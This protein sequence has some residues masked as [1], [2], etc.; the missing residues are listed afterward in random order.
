[1]WQAHRGNLYGNCLP[2]L[3]QESSP[4]ENK[5]EEC[6]CRCIFLGVWPENRQLRRCKEVYLHPTFQTSLSTQIHL[7]SPLSPPA[8]SSIQ[9]FWTQILSPLKSSTLFFSLP[10]LRTPWELLLPG[11]SAFCALFPVLYIIWERL[12]FVSFLPLAPVSPHFSLNT[13]VTRCLLQWG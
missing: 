4:T 1:M 12:S 8:D 3:P 2:S 9:S 10:G 13:A 6:Y 7:H 11:N 5:L